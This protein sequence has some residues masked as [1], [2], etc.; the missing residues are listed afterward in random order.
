MMNVERLGIHAAGA[1]A[2]AIISLAAFAAIIRPE[3][4]AR[5]SIRDQAR[6]RAE[7][8]AEIDAAVAERA[9]LRDVIDDQRRRI[10]ASPIRLREHDAL[11]AV[12]ASLT[13]LAQRRGVALDRLEPGKPEQRGPLLVTPIRL[14]GTT[15][16]PDAVAFFDEL[17]A[18]M[19]DI[20][21]VRL[22]IDADR[23]AQTDTAATRAS[24]AADLAWS[25]VSAAPAPAPQTPI[26][27]VPAR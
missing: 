24:I 23:T 16:F 17:R 13:D 15:S 27:G 18:A 22:A 3:L 14:A 1:A 7:R 20:A 11:N 10:D 9:R 26:A 5:D 12:I 4:N 8:R 19:P 6:S 25:A 2:C 21:C